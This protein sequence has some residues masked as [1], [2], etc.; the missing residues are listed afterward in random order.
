M[1]RQGLIHLPDCW[2][3]HS[4]FPAPQWQGPT[5]L[6]GLLVL[7]AA[8]QRLHEHAAPA[9][10]R[11][12]Q[13]RE[14]A[15]GGAQ[16]GSASGGGG[17]GTRG[18]ALLLMS[19][20]G[21]SHTLQHPPKQATR[22]PSTHRGFRQR[23]RAPTWPDHAAHA[24]D[25]VPLADLGGGGVEGVHGLAGG[26]G[27]ERGEGGCGRVTVQHALHEQAAAAGGRQAAQARPSRVPPPCWPSAR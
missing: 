10:G 22:I 9:A 8:G 26:D 13:Q 15:C 24:V 23:P 18:G 12:Q 27:E 11:A 21:C 1:V 4:A 16:G 3:L 20:V 6:E 2:Q 17:R 19:H 14:A 5:H 25:D 7:Q